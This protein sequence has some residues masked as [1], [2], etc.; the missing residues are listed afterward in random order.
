M[1]ADALSH[2]PRNGYH[3]LENPVVKALLKS[4][5]ETDWT[6]FNGNPS[7]I[8]C[9]SCQMILDRMTTKQWKK[10]QANDEIIS[11]VVKAMENSSEN[12]A[13]SS[14]LARQ[15]FRHRNK[16]IKR[17]GLLYVMRGTDGLLSL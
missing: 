13:F 10:E 11:Q 16:L 4:S 8:V 14:E 1:D 12:H 7:E 5:Q 17:H 2:L 9:K 15:M 3:E 6:D